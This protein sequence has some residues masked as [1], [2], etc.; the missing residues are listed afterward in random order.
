MEPILNEE[1]EKLANPKSP[2]YFS[3]ELIR[4]RKFTEKSD[5]WSIGCVMF[6]I[7]VLRPAFL[8]ENLTGSTI[9]NN[10]NYPKVPELDANPRLKSIFTT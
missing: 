9:S 3:P 1:F 2:C 5:L 6:E 10:N 4:T 7:Y 8:S